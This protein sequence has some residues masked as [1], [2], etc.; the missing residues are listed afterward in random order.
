[1]VAV[2]ATCRGE[3]SRAFT[4]RV[5]PCGHI[6]VRPTGLLVT[7]AEAEA[8]AIDLEAQIV[9]AVSTYRYLSETSGSR[10]AKVRRL[11]PDGSVGP[12]LWRYT[13]QVGE[14][15][16]VW[17][18][19]VLD[20]SALREQLRSELAIVAAGC[21]LML[22]KVSLELVAVDDVHCRLRI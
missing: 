17:R 1:V 6:E 11:H 14:E 4:A 2:V 12:V 5:G 20:L 15:S 8:Q 7:R 3:E 13:A 19:R 22:E 21:P 16:R 9:Y 10:R 18:A